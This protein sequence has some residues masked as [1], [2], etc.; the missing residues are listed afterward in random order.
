VRTRSGLPLARPDRAADFLD[1]RPASLRVLRAASTF[2]LGD[3]P[4]Q[5]EVR[6]VLGSLRERLE[7]AGCQVADAAPYR[8]PL[9]DGTAVAPLHSVQQESTATQPDGGGQADTSGDVITVVTSANLNDLHHCQLDGH[10]GQIAKV[11]SGIRR[12]VLAGAG[13]GERARLAHQL[14]QLAE[15]G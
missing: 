8:C 9:P 2:D 10:G 13:A 14:V 7:Q 1:L 12:I 11:G 6:A 5:P 3:L 15:L 4:V